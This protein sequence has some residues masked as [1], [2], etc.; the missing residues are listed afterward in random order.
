[1]RSLNCVALAEINVSVNMILNMIYSN[2][3]LSKCSICFYVM[4]MPKL[5]VIVM[6]L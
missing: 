2:V 3:M 6:T 1:M 4:L 5:H